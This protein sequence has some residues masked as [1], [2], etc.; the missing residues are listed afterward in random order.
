[1]NWLLRNLEN[2]KFMLGMDSNYFYPMLISPLLGMGINYLKGMKERRERKI[3]ELH[4]KSE[5]DNFYIFVMLVE[6]LV[7]VLS[8][9]VVYLFC[10]IIMSIS[11]WGGGRLG[12]E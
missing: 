11:F 4:C 5:S 10:E 8:L 12:D 7:I 3:F 1:M 9:F 2:C 6:I